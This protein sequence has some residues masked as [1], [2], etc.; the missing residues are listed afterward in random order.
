MIGFTGRHRK[1][2]FT[3]AL[4]PTDKMRGSVVSFLFSQILLRTMTQADCLRT[5]MT[6]T[7]LWCGMTGTALAQD[8]G[9]LTAL[10]QLQQ[11]VNA[12]E[13][14]L[15]ILR[16]ILE[17]RGSTDGEQRSSSRTPSEIASRS[18]ATAASGGAVT[19]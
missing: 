6:L 2:G 7:L 5:V 15:E 13:A 1:T 16:Q 19:S 9:S 18:S 17:G 12:Q 8:A 4:R 3:C 10:E 14:E 11:Q